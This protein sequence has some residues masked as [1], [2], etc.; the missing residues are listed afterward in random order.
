MIATYR[1]VFSTIF[2][3]PLITAEIYRTRSG[4]RRPSGNDSSPAEHAA[5][6]GSDLLLALASG[7]FLALHFGT[8][9]TSL[10]LTSVAS[11]TVLVTT[12]PIIVAGVSA[13]LLGDRLKR[14]S[15]LFML[16]AL[17]G[18]AL[19]AAAG[20]GDGQSRLLG[21]LLAVGG[22]VAVSGYIIIGRVLR[23]RMSLNRYT[24]IVYGTAGIL[25][26]ATTAIAGHPLLVTSVRELVIFVALALLCTNLGHSLISWSL[27]YVRPT[28]VSVSILGEPVVATTLA[29]IIF[30]EVPTA[31][32]FTGGAIVLIAIALFVRQENQ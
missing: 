6:R 7:V 11:A 20:A 17:A 1:L 26:V 25:L 3:L 12:H 18:G 19:L 16:A 4:T 32:T 14:S 13:V 29:L 15:V 21:N 22:A 24:L 30:Q 28:L 23:Q 27:K 8:W 10:S 2:V 9:I 5:L 31:W